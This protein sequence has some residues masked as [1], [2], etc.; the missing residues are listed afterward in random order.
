MKS[1]GKKVKIMGRKK[2]HAEWVA[3][4]EDPSKKGA[5]QIS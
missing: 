4:A 5:F 1:K 2:E 3:A